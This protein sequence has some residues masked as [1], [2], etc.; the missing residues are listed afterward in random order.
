MILFLADY[1]DGAESRDGVAQRIVA[2][3]Q[4]FLDDRRVYLGLSLKRFWVPRV[5]REGLRTVVRAN[6]ITGIALVIATAVRCRVA[7]VHSAYGALYAAYVLPFIRFVFDVHGV[8]PEEQ[9]ILGHRWR[10][11]LL[12]RVEA[13]CLRFARVVVCV[14]RE[15]EGHVIRKNPASRSRR[16]VLPIMQPLDKTRRIAGKERPAQGRLRVV[17]SGGIQHWQNLDRMVEAMSHTRDR[18]D[19]S[20]F[21]PAVTTCR[22]KL[23]GAGV[24]A[25]VVSLKREELYVRY[26]EAHLGFIL[27]DH[28]LINRVACPT[29]LSEY[30]HFGIVPIVLQ[31]EIG[32]MAQLGYRYVLLEDFEAGRVPSEQELEEMRRRN[33]EVLDGWQ[34]SFRAGAEELVEAVHG[35]EA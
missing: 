17:Y 18:F 3:D 13:L 16:I 25:D 11:R 15:M 30:M 22:E 9:E 19:F 10:A 29:K 34:A 21:T 27:R 5:R 4:L 14:T 6:A 24:A 2:I 26:G 33:W 35:L 23:E 8:V 12:A 31:P 28:D 7:Y 32:D 1:P 20:I